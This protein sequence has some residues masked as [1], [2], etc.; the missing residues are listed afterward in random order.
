[1]LLFVFV[2]FFYLLFFIN[3]DRNTVS[4]PLLQTV[5]IEVAYVKKIIVTGGTHTSHSSQSNKQTF[6]VSL[7]NVCSYCL[8]V[9]IQ[10][11]LNDEITDGVIYF[12]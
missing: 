4:S 5:L 9:R 10:N 2:F 1:M 6:D 7:K 3:E 11:S 12:T 8:F